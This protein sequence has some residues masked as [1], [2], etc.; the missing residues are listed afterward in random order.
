MALIHVNPSDK[1]VYGIDQD[2]P[3]NFVEPTQ[4]TTEDG[5]KEGL[6]HWPKKGGGLAREEKG[7]KVYRVAIVENTPS[8]PTSRNLHGHSRGRYDK[9][10]MSTLVVA[11]VH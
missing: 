10:G 7:T 5:F 6:L 8:P 2:V 4:R 9:P 11:M 3:R 1:A